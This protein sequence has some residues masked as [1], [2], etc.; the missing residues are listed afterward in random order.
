LN[1]GGAE[2]FV[3]DVSEVQKQQGLNPEIVNLGSPDDPL[4]TTAQAAGIKVHSLGSLQR[5]RRWQRMLQRARDPGSAVCHIHSPAVLKTFAPILPLLNT[6]LI[7]TRHG[8]APLD[9][10]KWR[11]LHRWAHR[12]IDFTT[13]VS[14]SAYDTFHH[15]Q[16]W[17]RDKTTVIL[18]GVYVPDL[19]DNPGEQSEHALSIGCVGRL[20]QLKAQSHLIK[21]L[22]G[23][24]LKQTP[25]KLHLYGSGPEQGNLEALVKERELTNQ[26]HFHGDV[27]DRE[28]IYASFN[29]LVVCSESE[30]LSLAIMEAMA[31]K[32]PVVATNVGG[33]P[34]LVIDGKTG[35][36]YEYG[37]LDSLAKVISKLTKAPDLVKQLGSN[38]RE[39]VQ[40]NFSINKTC[41]EYLKIYQLSGD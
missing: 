26:V 19:S 31:R 35:Y 24:A 6:R 23:D 12:F 8:S 1:V 41:D 34:Q 3:L 4:C 36:L 16:Q 21:A 15:N 18:N 33:N 22:S 29:V 39:H 27:M 32:I 14:H 5:I 20:V 13:F 7:Y 38:A 17:D 37:D 9:S 40:E 2:R 10:S 25:V 30:G 11:Y 28:A